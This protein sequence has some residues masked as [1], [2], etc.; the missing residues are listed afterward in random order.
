MTEEKRM[1]L[2]RAV[3]CLVVVTGL[4]G[5]VLLAGGCTHG[6]SETQVEDAGTVPSE[7]DRQAAILSK[8]DEP[9][10][11]EMMEGEGYAV[12]IDEDGD[13]EWSIEGY[14]AYILVLHDGESL[15]FRAAFTDTDMTL[16]DVNEWNATMLFSRMYL[17]DEGDAVLELDLDLAG[18]VT[19]AHLIEWFGICRDSFL[20][21]TSGMVT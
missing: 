13:I 18:G 21:W 15:L 9:Q 6:P 3:V 5:S 10:L 16:Q 20:E 7:A 14:H 2:R 19:S 11:K 1:V 17:D 4:C 8:I 12:S